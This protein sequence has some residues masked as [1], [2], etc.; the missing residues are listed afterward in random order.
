MPQTRAERLLA[1]FTRRLAPIPKLAL[2]RRCG[3][4][5]FPQGQ[6]SHAILR[7]INN[8][9][10]YASRLAPRSPSSGA[11]DDESPPSYTSRVVMPSLRCR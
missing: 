5:F 8:K 7:T 10:S 4:A 2:R 3:A 9:E 11:N 1:L 6:S